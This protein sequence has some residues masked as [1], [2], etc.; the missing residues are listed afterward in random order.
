MQMPGRSNAYGAGVEYRYAYN[1]MEV[2][3]EVSGDGNSYTT[4]FRQ[5]DPRLGRWKSLDP[6]M[7]KRPDWTPYRAFFNNPVVFSD[8]NGLYETEHDA[9]VMRRRA[10][11]QGVFTTGKDWSGVEIKGEK[12][13]YYF[14]GTNQNG[15]PGQTVYMNKQFKDLDRE[16]SMLG[17]F[18]KALNAVWDWLTGSKMGKGSNS[19]IV[20]DGTTVTTKDKDKGKNQQ[21]IRVKNKQFSE[22]NGDLFSVSKGGAK[23]YS[24]LDVPKYSTE[25]AE[26]MKKVFEGLEKVRE[27]YDKADEEFNKKITTKQNA[28]NI[29]VYVRVQ[30]W[31]KTGDGSYSGTDEKEGALLT[32]QD[33][34]ELYPN[35]KFQEKE[36]FDGFPIMNVAAYGPN[37]ELPQQYK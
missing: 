34:I 29:V 2:D 9:R 25:Q 7:A 10:R 17:K 22:T 37:G 3:G 35:G 28:E 31:I 27:T 4:E 30:R 15:E 24:P 23:K 11:R 16:N 5:Y 18:D 8:I 21:A 20:K 1:G 33:A 36:S 32:Y 14:E 26:R 19:S 13:K 6:L 12:G